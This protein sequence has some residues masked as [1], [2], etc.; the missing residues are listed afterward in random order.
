MLQC[1]QVHLSWC[2]CMGKNEYTSAN[3]WAVVRVK[4]DGKLPTNIE[5]YSR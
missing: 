3:K 5:H 2:F 4:L 1:K